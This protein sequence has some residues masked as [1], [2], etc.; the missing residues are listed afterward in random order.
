MS[1]NEVQKPRNIGLI[2]NSDWLYNFFAH[3][4]ILLTQPLEFKRFK[5]VKEQKR[6]K[7]S[8]LTHYQS[9]K[10]VNTRQFI[11]AKTTQLIFMK[12]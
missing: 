12:E 5:R 3:Y 4:Y 8:L 9:Q 10:S 7:T 2:Y 6:I 1:V 11:F